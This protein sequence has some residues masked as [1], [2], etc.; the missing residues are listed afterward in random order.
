MSENL[1]V[2]PLDAGENEQEN[3]AD[4]DER[5]AESSEDEL[6]GGVGEPEEPGVEL[7]DQGV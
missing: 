7:E 1:G 2:E 6:I 4:D 5:P 3:A